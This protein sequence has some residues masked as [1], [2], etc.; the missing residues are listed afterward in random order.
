ME[1][2]EFSAHLKPCLF[3]VPEERSPGERNPRA[4]IASVAGKLGAGVGKLSAGGP[5]E[6]N[7]LG[8]F[9]FSRVP[10]AARRFSLSLS[11]S[12]L[13]GQRHRIVSI[14]RTDTGT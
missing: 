7:Q 1:P 10:L 8:L 4:V 11:I 14:V 2:A 12:C 6:K 3:S 5:P 9:E 13:A